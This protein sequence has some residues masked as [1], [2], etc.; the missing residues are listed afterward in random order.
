MYSDISVPPADLRTT[1]QQRQLG[2]EARQQFP[3][4]LARDCPIGA[5]DPIALLRRQDRTRV[6]D[7]IPLRYARMSTDVFR[8][9]RGT[10]ALMAHDLERQPGTGVE[11]I[12]CGDAHLSNFGFYASPE[13]N[14]VFD[15]NDFDESAPAPWDWDVKRLVASAVLAARQAGMGREATEQLA[16]DVAGT[17]RTAIRRLADRSLI[18]RYYLSVRDDAL[19]G[20]L[21]DDAHD[22]IAKVTRKARR[23][24]S[25]RAAR[26]LLETG[27]DGVLRFQ[28]NPPVLSHV[29]DAVCDGLQDVYRHYQ[30]STRPDIAI[31]LSSCR[32]VDVARRVVGVGSVG[33]RCYVLA[34][35]DPSGS[36]LILQIKEAQPSVL[37]QHR[38]RHILPRRR[39]LANRIS[40]GRRV[41]TCQQ[42]LQ[43][44]S[45]AF[46]GW[47]SFGGHDYYVRQFRDMKGSFN[48]DDLDAA[49]LPRYA[50]AC[51]TLLAR[52]HAQSPMCAWIAGYLGKSTVFDRAVGAWA[53]DYADQA[54]RDYDALREAISSGRVTAAEQ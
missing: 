3:R 15:L 17:Y 22:E 28:E 9:Y 36:P 44:V 39:L 31:L 18:E 29:D 8:F 1:E 34:L 10:A 11:L 16:A 20:R 2:R 6:P 49:L 12:S 53:L 45:D 14:L 23:R 4:S 46:L 43:A 25:E 52:A 5:R 50:N 26:K 33:T 30:A 13:R 48:V 38:A 19:T 40:E 47:L 42:V 32:V 27:P 51:A 24:T 21:L 54:E 41:V 35:L 7:L 37:V